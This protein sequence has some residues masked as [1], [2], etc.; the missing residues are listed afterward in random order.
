MLGNSFWL[1][2]TLSINVTHSSSV[3]VGTEPPVTGQPMVF[4]RAA[5]L[6]KDR[7]EASRGSLKGS[8]GFFKGIYRVS[9]L[10]RGSGDLVS[11][12]I[13]K[14]TIVISTYNPN[15]GTYNPTY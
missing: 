6:F 5:D 4:L 7:L 10:L 2:S 14:V 11:R 13:S 9:G 15:Y 12:V 8:I 3:C 1:L